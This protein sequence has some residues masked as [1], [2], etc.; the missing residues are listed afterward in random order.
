MPQVGGIA[1]KKGV[2]KESVIS[3]NFRCLRLL[4]EGLS[5]SQGLNVTKEKFDT[6]KMM[7]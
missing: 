6:I 4:P 3:P 5:V 2:G 7:L 1:C